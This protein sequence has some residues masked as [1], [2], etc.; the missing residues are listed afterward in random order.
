MQNV[1]TGVKRSEHVYDNVNTYIRRA[2]KRI[3][4]WCETTEH[5][6]IPRIDTFPTN[7]FGRP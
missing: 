5:L 3:R 1:I 6:P 7:V 2:S 4:F